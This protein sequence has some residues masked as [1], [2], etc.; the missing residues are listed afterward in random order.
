MKPQMTNKD[1]YQLATL[2]LLGMLDENERADY[3]R[4]FRA[5]SPEVQADIRR[6]QLRAADLDALLPKVEE[7]YGLRDRVLGAVREAVAAIRLEPIARIGPGSA[8]ASIW[9]TTHLWR[10]ACIGFIAATLV[11]SVYVF[12]L[13]DSIRTIRNDALS[14]NTIT[15]IANVTGSG[16]ATALPRFQVT[17]FSPAAADYD[18]PAV[19]QLYYDPQKQRAFLFADNL[20]DSPQEYTLVLRG[21]GGQADQPVERF[22]ARF[23]SL[24]TV[25]VKSVSPADFER[26]AI[27]VPTGDDGKSTALLV[28]KGV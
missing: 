26:L 2:D 28:A 5:A 19:A 4:A 16:F 15:G 22:R 23:G 27:H 11:L 9:R 24:A 6:E 21:T 7:P 20:P 12:W 10:A 25:E 14:S 17:T 13:N 8:H 18:G 1:L 3:E